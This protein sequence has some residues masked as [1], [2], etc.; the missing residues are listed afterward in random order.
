[1]KTNE[2]GKAALTDSF[3]ISGDS[4]YKNSDGENVLPLGTVTIQ[5]TKAPKGYLLNREVFIRKITSEGTAEN[6]S[7]YNAPVISENIISGE[8]HIIKFGQDADDSS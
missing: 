2:S 3:K 1:M 8:L 4:F 6:V 5:E 7:T